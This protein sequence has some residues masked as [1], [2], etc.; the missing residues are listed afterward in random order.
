MLAF[1][2]RAAPQEVEVAC[3][4]DVA[5]RAALLGYGQFNLWALSAKD[6]GSIGIQLPEEVGLVVP[7]LGCRQGTIAECS[8]AWCAWVSSGHPSAERSRATYGALLACLSAGRAFQ[9][10]P[11]IRLAA[12]QPIASPWYV[13]DGRHRLFAAYAHGRERPHTVIEVFWNGTP[14]PT[15]F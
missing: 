14:P 11:I 12:E 9:L 10:R 7:G 3:P 13:F 4:A 5:T 15:R 1:V 6:A 2:R 8:F